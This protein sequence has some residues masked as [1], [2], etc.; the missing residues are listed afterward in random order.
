MKVGLFTVLFGSRPFSNVLKYVAEQGCG[1]VEIGAGNYPGS[2]HINVKELL[3]S[4]PKRQELM[5]E[6]KD[7]GLT[8]SALS[9]H[10]NPLHPNKKIAVAHHKVH[11]DAVVLAEKLGID[12]VIN[13]SG[14][15]GGAPGDKQPNWATCPW[16]PEYLEVLDYQWNK[17]AIPYWKAESKFA[18][19]HGIKIAFEAHPGFLVYNP[20]TMLK[21]R[22]N[23]GSNLGSNIDPSHFWWQGIDPLQAVRALKGCIY[24]VHAKDTRI[25]PANMAFNGG[26]DTRHY[27]NEAERTWIFRTV[28][29]GHGESWWRD[30]VSVLRTYGYDGA[31]SIEHED[32]LM[33][34]EEGFEKAAA[35]LKNIVINHPKPGKMHWA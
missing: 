10:G 28:G 19:A 34:T 5:S 32:S 13:F 29:Y 8:V 16:P 30:F 21:L 25:D 23:C 3:A 11:R 18:K 4:E 15:P 14:C 20:Y 2:P 7:Y 9:V 35:F 12:V 33:T 1:A 26:L 17:V 31:L 6:I 22:E 27:G 24:H